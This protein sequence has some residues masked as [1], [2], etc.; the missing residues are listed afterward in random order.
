MVWRDKSFAH[1]QTNMH[2]PSTSGN[3]NDKQAIAMKP[4]ITSDYSQ[5]MG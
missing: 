3:F 5:H 2:N 1:V 4:R